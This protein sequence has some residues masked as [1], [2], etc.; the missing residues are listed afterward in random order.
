MPERFSQPRPSG[1]LTGRIAHKLWQERQK[2]VER[3]LEIRRKVAE[4]KAEELGKAPSIPIAFESY[5]DD[6]VVDYTGNYHGRP[7]L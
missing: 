2:E 5:D 7:T 3:D 1:D 4:E 6:D